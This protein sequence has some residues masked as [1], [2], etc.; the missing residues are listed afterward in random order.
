MTKNYQIFPEMPAAE[1]AAL[2]ASIA[3]HGVEVPII[4]DQKGA[5][6]DGYHRSRACD[7]LGVFCPREVRKFKNEAEKFELSLRLNCSRRHLNQKQ[8][9]ALI[10]AYLLHDA[11][12]ADAY[13]GQIVGCSKNTVAS[14]RAELESKSQIDFCS[15]RRGVNGRRRPARYKKII[16]N[17]ANEAKKA[18]DAINH[19]PESCNGKTID[20]ITG[21]R[22]AKRNKVAKRR[23]KLRAI[24]VPSS[25]D[26]IRLY[27]CPFQKL[28]SVAKIKRN[29]VHLI[30]TDIPYGQ[31]FLPQVEEL[32]EFAKRVLKPGGIFVTYA[33]QY[34]LPKVIELLG[35]S[36]QYRWVNA[37]IWAS[38]C[39]A[40]N[41]GNG[42]K[43]RARVLSNWKP[44]LIFSKGDS[45]RLNGQW[46][47]ISFVEEKE[48]D[49]HEWQQPISEVEKLVRDF[50][51][52][53]DLVLD[54]C[55]GGF[56][57]AI[58]CL[59]LNRRFVGCDIE[60]ENVAL[61]QERLELAREEG[62]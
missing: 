54:P 29:S 40:V 39:N 46:N 43:S 14:V 11:Q 50:S 28:E 38:D 2:K 30:A 12:I 49:W 16:A 13:L 21:L 56:T 3:E 60:A 48:K 31:E 24:T 36:L 10:A 33:G 25:A 47:D 27:H 9:R 8:K 45:I 42:K 62:N 44:I 23:R 37:S 4:V 6:V 1:F 61:G 26:S 58:A 5:V 35:K 59:N 18:L 34:W 41:F 57:T 52:P 17:S 15:H 19:L 51:E 55:G 53:G 22:R 20:V 7:E 32:G